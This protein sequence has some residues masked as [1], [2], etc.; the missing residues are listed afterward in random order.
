MSGME[1]WIYVTGAIMA[2]AWWLG[3]ASF[4][5][6]VAGAWIV[7]GVTAAIL[8]LLT[9][10]PAAQVRRLDRD[11]QDTMAALD[12][13]GEP[14]ARTPRPRRRKRPATAT[15]GTVRAPKP[16]TPIPGQGATRGGLLGSPRSNL[17][18]D[19]SPDER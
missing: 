17:L 2:A 5:I 16:R 1:R 14:P 7:V 6:L 11:V 3:V 18:A 19:P 10:R 15:Q 12:G 13:F 8:T 4:H 9:P